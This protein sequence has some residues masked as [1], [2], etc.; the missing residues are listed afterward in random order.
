MALIIS[1]FIVLDQFCF[2]ECKT[3]NPIAAKATEALSP[4]RVCG[5]TIEVEAL[6]FGAPPPHSCAEKR[7]KF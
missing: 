5:K 3:I 6:L 1:S 7:K 4:V 2:T